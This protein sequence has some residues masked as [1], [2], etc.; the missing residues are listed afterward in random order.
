MDPF[1]DRPQETD[2]PRP[3]R[4][5]VVILLL[6]L[7]FCGMPFMGFLCWVFVPRGP[8]PPYFPPPRVITPAIAF[9]KQGNLITAYQT[10]AGDSPITYLQKVSSNGDFL[11]G[12]GGVK[13]DD[14]Q[15]Q[16]QTQEGQRSTFSYMV[17]PRDGDLVVVGG[18]AGRPSARKL[19]TSGAPVWVGEPIAVGTPGR[20]LQSPPEAVGC[21]VTGLDSAGNLQF[22]SMDADWKP[23]WTAPSRI[24]N[25]D[26]Y[27]AVCDSK[28]YTWVVWIEPH[29]PSTSP[30]IYLQVIDAS[31]R[32]VWTQPRCL[33]KPSPAP[34]GGDDCDA[35]ATAGKAGDVI[36]SW[37]VE[38]HRGP[39]NMQRVDLSGKVLWS[40]TTDYL[41]DHAWWAMSRLFVSDGQGGVFA[42]SNTTGSVPGRP[43]EFKSRFLAVQH[44]DAEGRLQW[45]EGGI[46]LAIGLHSDEMLFGASSDG[47]GGA[48]VVWNDDVPGEGYVYY[49]QRIDSG[50]NE[51][52]Q[53]K[54]LLR[55]G[56]LGYADGLV[57]RVRD[58]TTYVSV[59]D[60]GDHYDQVPHIQK[61]TSD[62]A[63]PLGP[64]GLRFGEQ[65]EE[66]H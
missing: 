50:G 18:F 21:V 35:C 10:Q 14:I 55:I 38:Y 7:V 57:I 26:E 29:D 23:L 16:L 64:D 56:D 34:A 60:V 13:L 2:Q 8:H 40:L 59:A 42:F 61:I 17:A 47:S 24:A 20:P 3:A 6:V 27:N 46:E 37:V 19:D 25:V 12:G 65:S 48:V 45:G 5:W 31:G 54:G 52:W 49:A 62:G 4:V 53:D 39:L 22:Q 66:V 30:G 36:V 15:P 9:D 28:G 63:L 41:D 58:G 44:I 43:P 11:W 33:K 32:F 1:F 51:L